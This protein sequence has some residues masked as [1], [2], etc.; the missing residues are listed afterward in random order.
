MGPGV[1]RGMVL[2]A[3]A[4]DLCLAFVVERSAAGM[5]LVAAVVIVAVGAL[6][7]LEHGR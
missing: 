6:V 1:L 7:V 3:F 4:T 5:A 2:A